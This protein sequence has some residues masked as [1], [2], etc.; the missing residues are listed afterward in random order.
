MSRREFISA[1]GGSHAFEAAPGFRVSVL[2]SG[3]LGARNLTTCVVHAQPGSRLPYHTH[4]TGEAITVVAGEA[5]AYVEGRR[6][7]LRALDA[8]FVPAGVAHS[9]ENALPDQVTVL[10]TAFPTGQVTRD[11][12]ADTFPLVDRQA[13]DSSTPESLVR[14]AETAAYSLAPGTEFRDLFAGRFGARGVCGGHGVFPPGTGL[15]CHYHV[16]DESI[17]IVD[18]VAIC[19]VAGAEY[20]LRDLQTAC[21]PDQRPHRFVNRG[22]TP[23]AMIWVYAGDEPDRVLVDQSLCDGTAICP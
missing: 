18:G 17:T 13:T 1:A 12:V 10:H 3:E 6:Y 5:N 20:E 23:M 15:P 2:A 7:R 9:V 19:Q 8:I 11:F 21:I 14:S 4:P 22:A 16:Y